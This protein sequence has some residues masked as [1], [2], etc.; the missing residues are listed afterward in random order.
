MSKL[1]SNRFLLSIVF[2][3]RFAFYLFKGVL[4]FYL[5]SENTFTA[6]KTYGIHIT[7]KVLIYSLPVVMGLVSDFVDR[8]KMFKTGLIISIIG[9][10]IIP[11]LSFSYFSL[12]FAIV[13]PASGLSILRPNILILIGDNASQ[14]GSNQHLLR[15]FLYMGLLVSLA[16]IAVNIIDFSFH[17][18]NL[19]LILLLC[20]VFILIA[21][22][23]FHFL[24]PKVINQKTN[25]GQISMRNIVVLA[26]ILLI[27][28]TIMILNEHMT[29]RLSIEREGSQ[30]TLQNLHNLFAVPFSVLFLLLLAIKTFRIKFDNIIAVLGITTVGFALIFLLMNLYESSNVSFWSNNVIWFSALIAMTGTLLFPVMAWLIYKYSIRYKGFAFGLFYSVELIAMSTDNLEMNRIHLLCLIV[31]LFLL[32]VTI[33]I[34]RKKIPPK[35]PERV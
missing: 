28:L 12:I 27:S 20:S 34:L 24:V 1:K 33:I 13:V 14:F 23:V 7:F 9:Y 22:L 29:P 6:E 17:D 16:P 8:Q 11:V 18:N 19:W 2:I 26:A 15:D 32:G 30:W 25:E 4:I 3:E 10:A 35:V 31:V 21:F 5:L